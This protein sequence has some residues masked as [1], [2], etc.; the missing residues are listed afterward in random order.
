[1]S[2]SKTSTT[3]TDKAIFKIVSQTWYYLF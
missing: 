2:E 3:A 1:M